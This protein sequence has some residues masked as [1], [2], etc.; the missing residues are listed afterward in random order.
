[1]LCVVE[2]RKGRVIIDTRCGSAGRSI[3]VAIVC[4][5]DEI[6]FLLEYSRDAANSA[7][8]HWCESLIVRWLEE[9]GLITGNAY[10]AT[11]DTMFS[12]DGGNL[13][14]DLG[15]TRLSLVCHFTYAS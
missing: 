7:Y 10:G 1:M 4:G 8:Q 9:A 5:W 11:D 6:P 13:S 14:E 12:F 15:Q 2:F 3:Y